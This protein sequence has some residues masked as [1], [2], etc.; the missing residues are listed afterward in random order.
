MEK[1]LSWDDELREGLMGPQIGLD[2]GCEDLSMFPEVAEESIAAPTPHH[3]HC[4]YG[5]T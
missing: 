3:L 4:F 1:G 2:K 5:E